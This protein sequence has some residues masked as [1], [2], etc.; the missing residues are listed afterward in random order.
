MQQNHHK[1]YQAFFPPAPP[2]KLI[3]KKTRR[4]CFFTWKQTS[5][6]WLWAESLLATLLRDRWRSMERHFLLHLVHNKTMISPAFWFLRYKNW[7]EKNSPEP[8]HW[9]MEE[10]EEQATPACS[11]VENTAV[12]TGMKLSQTVTVLN[13][14]VVYKRKHFKEN[15]CEQLKS[16]TSTGA[17]C[18]CSN[19]MY[20][21]VPRRLTSCSPMGRKAVL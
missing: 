13:I 8:T 21:G 16:S 12:Q 15:N 5:K 4:N 20:T 9:N 11:C 6:Q 18:S 19:E 10:G 1:S 14:L 2:L 7:G 17:K 3:T